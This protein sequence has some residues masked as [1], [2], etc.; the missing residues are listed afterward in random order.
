MSAVITCL[1]GAL[2]SYPLPAQTA[3]TLR[4]LSSTQANNLLVDIDADGKLVFQ[5]PEARTSSVRDEVVHWRRSK[6]ISS[7]TAIALADGSWLSGRITWKSNE[8]L[9]LSSDWFDPL[10]LKLA[11]VRAIVTQPSPSVR[12]TLDLQSRLLKH[13]GSA[14]QVW[15]IRGEPITGVLKAQLASSVGE[16][17]SP[18]IDWRLR[19]DKSDQ[20]IAL[21]NSDI[22]ALV[23]SPALHRPYRMQPTA[24]T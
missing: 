11:Q 12:H 8:S 7:R 16:D 23:F 1:A 24:R 2:A 22:A 9:Q 17:G 21:T 20:F 5:S 10:E 4:L 18:R 13:S 19:P 15:R 14:D 6:A 3:P